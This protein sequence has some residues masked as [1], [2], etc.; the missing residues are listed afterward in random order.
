MLAVDLGGSSGRVMSGTVTDRRL[1]TC[2]VHRFPNAAV[3]RSRADGTSSLRW[4]FTH[5]VDEVTKGLRDGVANINEVQS[6]GVDGWGLDYG[7]VGPDDEVLDEPFSYRD[8]R[9]IGAIEEF[10]LNERSENTY[11]RTGIAPMR[12]NTIYQLLRD[13][14]LAPEMRVLLLPD[15]LGLQLSGVN[16]MELTNASTT[17]L[18]LANSFDLDSMSLQHVGVRPEMLAPL[19]RSGT[20]LGPLTARTAADT[21]LNSSV[22]EVA[23]GSHDTA[24]AVASLPTTSRGVAYVSA[25]T[26]ALAGVVTDTPVLSV[27]A[28][29]ARLTN[30]RHVDG[31]NRLQRNHTGLWVLQECMREWALTTALDFRELMAAATDLPELDYTTDLD[32]SEFAAPGRMIAK[33]RAAASSRGIDLTTPPEVARFVVQ[34]LAVTFADTIASAAEI[35]NVQVN[36]I[37]VIGGGSQN[38]LL[39]RA[40]AAASGLTVVAG[41]VEASAIGNLLIQA[42]ALGAIDSF[43]D[44]G[45]I[46]RNSTELAIY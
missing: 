29:R 46:V 25:G 23:V 27:R 45:E 4:D 17:G 7:I 34:S 33:V 15:L 22:V 16:R 41:P 9:T 2:I 3:Q 44:F 11:A 32:A 13:D 24:S 21:G 18:L 35:G 10:Q 39:C 12:E 31:R 5:I 28:L 30:E 40:L 42:Y 6:V 8:D 38:Q 19:V 36:T 20:V 1:E 43:S 14:R 26:W 37:H